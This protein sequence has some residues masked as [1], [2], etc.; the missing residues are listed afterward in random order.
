MGIE[1]YREVRDAIGRE[2]EKTI[3]RVMAVGMRSK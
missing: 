2:V 1:K 3:E